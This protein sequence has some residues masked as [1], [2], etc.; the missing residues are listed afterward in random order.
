M[1]RLLLFLSLILLGCNTKKMAHAYYYDYL[2]QDI[3]NGEHYINTVKL[4]SD[5]I[6]KKRDS[7][8]V[9]SGFDNGFRNDEFFIDDMFNLSGL[10]DSSMLSIIKTPEFEFFRDH[11]FYAADLYFIKKINNVV[12]LIKNNL[13]KSRI[14]TLK[15]FSLNKNDTIKKPCLF[16]YSSG[17]QHTE[18]NY[19]IYKNDTTL[20][21]KGN[22]YNTY[23]F[24]LVPKFIE[25]YKMGIHQT[26][27]GNADS[28]YYNVYIDKKTYLPIQVDDSF[29]HDDMDKEQKIS[30]EMVLSKKP[31]KIEMPFLINRDK[32]TQC[33]YCPRKNISKMHSVYN[34]IE[35]TK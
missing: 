6:F 19:I 8:F 1:Y 10:D 28:S 16:L 24:H 22:K 17:I 23:H 5:A 9:V 7:I 27:T 33:F 34:N 15:L 3:Q 31:K 18:I 20:K 21:I 30:Y 12:C 4:S 11:R 2:Y 35:P 25:L 26:L 29:F 32:T 13:E 14:D